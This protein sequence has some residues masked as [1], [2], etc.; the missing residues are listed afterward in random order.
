[1]EVDASDYITGV[2][3]ELKTIDFIYFHFFNLFSFYFP[4]IFLFLDLELEI[5]IILYDHI[6]HR[7][8]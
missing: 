3:P 4:F 5:N 8:I 7:R 2:I 1:M 6:S